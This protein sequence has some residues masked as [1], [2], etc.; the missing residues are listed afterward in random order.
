MSR[1]DVLE[2]DAFRNVNCLMVYL[3]IVRD[4]YRDHFT[5]SGNNGVARASADITARLRGK[6]KMRC[7]DLGP[8]NIM[9]NGPLSAF[10]GFRYGVVQVF[11]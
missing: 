8:T 4:S 6:E 10:L 3:M 1:L 9:G 2:V 7:L 11:E 5:C